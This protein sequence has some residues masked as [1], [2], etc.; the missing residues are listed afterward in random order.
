MNLWTIHILV[1]SDEESHETKHNTHGLVRLDLFVL[2]NAS[3]DEADDGTK[4]KQELK[5]S[6]LLSQE[7]DNFRKLLLIFKSVGPTFV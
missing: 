7:Q 4:P 1:G 6:E 3:S 2:L 5:E